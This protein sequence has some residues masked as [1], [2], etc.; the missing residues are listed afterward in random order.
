MKPLIPLLISL[1]LAGTDV[2][3]LLL[4]PT[5]GASLTVAPQQPKE[6]EIPTCGFAF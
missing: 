2:I 5:T 4:H 3:L 1:A 6:S